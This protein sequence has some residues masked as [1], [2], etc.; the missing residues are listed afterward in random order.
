MIAKGTGFV[1]G[2]PVAAQG[3]LVAHLKYVEH[4]SKTENESR[5]DRRIFTKDEDLVARSAAVQ[6]VMDHANTQ[7]AYHQIV[8]SPGEAEHIADW[9]EWT[10][11]VMDDLEKKQGRELHWYAVSY[12]NTDNPHVHVVLAGA[13]NNRINGNREAVKMDRCDYALLRQSGTDRSDRDW[14]RQIEEQVKE[15]DRRDREEI[16]RHPEPEPEKQPEHYQGGNHD[17]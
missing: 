4:R 11:G 6:D 17:R 9:R 12:N 13:G 10:R 14:Y 1:K 15:E 2:N 16:V 3:R 5:D 7:V 8:L